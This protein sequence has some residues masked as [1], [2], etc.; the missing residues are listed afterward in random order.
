MQSQLELLLPVY[1]YGEEQSVQS[2]HRE[3]WFALAAADKNADILTLMELENM[4]TSPADSQEAV[5]EDAEEETVYVAE[6]T[7]AFVPHEKQIQLDMA[8]LQNYETLV[9]QYYTIDSCT[10][11]GTDELDAERLAAMDLSISTEA[12]GPQILI[13]HTHSQEAFADSIPGDENTSIMAVGQHLADIL[14][15]EYGY[16]VLHHMGKYDV[17][18]RDNAYSR[19]LPEVEQI[20]ADNPSIQVVIDLHRDAVAEDTRLVM[21]LDGRP[22]ARFMFFNGVSRT[23]NTGN[24][25]YLYN[26]YQM[27]NL[28]FSFQMKC[29]AEEYYPGL[30]RKNY[31]NGYRYNMHVCPRTLLIE[32]GAQNNTLEE[33][34]NACDPIAHLLDLVLSGEGKLSEE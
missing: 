33:A 10:M 12:D 9:N 1:S 23:K 2:L 22:T 25:E 14:E 7:T 6:Q 21:D 18:S 32:L 27:E 28:A 29:L 26:P 11:V 30:T 4:G 15:Q 17:E 19:S 20:L 3:D 34:M 13:Y 5:S 16:Q 31:I 24:I 8:S